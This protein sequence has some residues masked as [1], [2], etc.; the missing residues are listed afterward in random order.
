MKLIKTL[1]VTS[2]LMAPLAQAETIQVEAGADKQMDAPDR[3]FHATDTAKIVGNLIDGLVLRAKARLDES[4]I[5]EQDQPM[6]GERIIAVIQD[7]IGKGDYRT[8]VK[9]IFKKYLTEEEMAD[10][11]DF[12]DSKTGEKLKLI[13]QPMN[14]EVYQTTISWLDLVSQR[15]DAL[16]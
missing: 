8:N 4:R 7:E 14:A 12:Y 1:M 15:I 13:Q 9:N 16:Y 11:S 10:I 3:Y 2:L 6:Y 5:Q